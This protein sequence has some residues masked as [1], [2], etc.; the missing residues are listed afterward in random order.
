MEI[1]DRIQRAENTAAAR[2]FAET[3]RILALAKGSISEA[4]RLAFE[5]SSPRVVAIFERA[6][7]GS[8]LGGTSP[9]WGDALSDYQQTA[10]G[11]IA[12]LRND[13]CF[14]AVLPYTTRLPFRTK[15][16]VSVTAITATETTE[17]DEKP[18]FDLAFAA[19]ELEPRKASATV[20][21]S[22]ELARIG[23]DNANALILTE[24][25]NA[26]IAGTD[27]VAI[28]ALIAATTPIP[29]SGDVLT[30]LA[31]LL[32]A[33]RSGASSRLFFV[34]EPSQAKILATLPGVNGA[35]FPQV[36]VN[37]GSIGGV[38]VLVSGQLAPGTAVLFDA[39]AIAAASENVALSASREAV[40]TTVAS[41]AS[42]VSLWPQD[43]VALRAERWFGFSLLRADGV[44]SLSGVDYTPTSP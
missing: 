41:P 21:I 7:P 24:L 5:L 28:A 42:S 4:R 29:S 17:A 40:V 30:D 44:A 37:G 23:G 10:E 6:E 32:A 15:L 25:R 20:I 1:G 27:S 43:L 16:A 35:A 9:S 36:N 18:V 34:I 19:T 14:D 2:D 3:A 8:A 22:T 11:F 39:T 12:S 13:G 33:V 26:V 38:T 31:A